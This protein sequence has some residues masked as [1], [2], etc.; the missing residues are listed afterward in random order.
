VGYKIVAKRENETVTFEGGSV[1]VAV[2]KARVWASEGWQVTVVDGD[3]RTLVPA[4]FEQILA[5]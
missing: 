1:L 4:E 2:A 3:G 5:A